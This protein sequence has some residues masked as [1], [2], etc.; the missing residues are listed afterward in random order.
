[1]LKCTHLLL[2]LTLIKLLILLGFGMENNLTHMENRD[3]WVQ[4]IPKLAAAICK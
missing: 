4:R 2:L 1:M 3:I